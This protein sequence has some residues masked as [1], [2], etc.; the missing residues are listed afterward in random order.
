LLERERGTRGREREG[1]VR[2]GSFELVRG[3]SCSLCTLE[4]A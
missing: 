1:G 3:W 4:Q 2:C